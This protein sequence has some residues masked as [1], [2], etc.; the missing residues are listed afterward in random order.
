MLG[1][2]NN[3]ELFFFALFYLVIAG[4]FILFLL[5]E[6]DRLARSEG[7]LEAILNCIGDGVF[8]IDKKRKIVLFNPMA[9]RISGYSKEEVKGKV[10]NKVLK[11]VFE[12]NRKENKEFIESA[13]KF[14][15]VSKML[16]HTILIA[17]GGKEIPVDDSAAPLKDSLGKVAGCI[18]IFRDV[19]KQREIDRM[20]TDFVS[21]ASH[22]LRTPASAIKWFLETLLTGEEGKLNRKQQ[23][24][25]MEAYNANQRMISLINDL[26]NVSR[27]EAG[28]M[29]VAPS[30]CDLYELTEGALHEIKVIFTPKKHKYTVKVPKDLPKVYADPQI[31][32]QILVNLLSNAA[33]YTNPE[34][35]I[36]IT[37]TKKP[38]TII[39]Q[40]KDNGVG[41][42]AYQQNR[43]FDRFFRADNVVQ[44]ETEGTGLGLFVVKN[45]VEMMG[46][47][48]WFTSREGKGSTFYFSMPLHI[49]NH[50][51][52]K[53]KNQKT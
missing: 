35:H 50:R 22:Q 32:R 10:Y 2:I 29:K 45:L 18:V 25:L 5:I 28:K 30:P 37:I 16:D 51:Y 4:F 31:L 14:G 53:Q 49:A 9:E 1:F 44:L 52:K 24:F 33:K 3:S 19:A 6:R 15:R 41:I 47:K 13:L 39:W 11:F 17:K 8:V 40:V 21:V 26:L 36:K 42:P 38:K 20:K 12:K 34:G 7:K 48:I 23:D 27:L 43:I 46:G